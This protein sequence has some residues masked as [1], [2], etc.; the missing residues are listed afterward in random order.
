MIVFFFNSDEGWGG[1]AYLYESRNF[2][3][4]VANSIKITKSIFSFWLS[5]VLY[6]TLFFKNSDSSMHCIY[7]KFNFFC[8]TK[9]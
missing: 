3:C 9:K 8:L 2:F 7:S 6:L 4:N 5:S 1:C